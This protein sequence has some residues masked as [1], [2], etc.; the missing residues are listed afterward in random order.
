[1]NF[2][3]R[4]RSSCSLLA[5][6]G[7]LTVACSQPPPLVP[8]RSG[9]ATSD[10]GVPSDS[11]VPDGGVGDT[12]VATDGGVDT[13]VPP[14][15]GGGPIF[16]PPRI[17]TC[18]G[19]MIPS[20]PT[21]TCRV[22]AGGTGLLITGDILT[23]GEVFRGGQ[24][25]VN[26]MGQITCAACDCSAMAAGATQI[27]CPDGVVSPGLVNAHDHITF[28]N[29]L[30]YTRTDE[31]YEHR[32]DWRAANDGHTRIRNAGGMAS[33]AQ[34]AWIEL[35]HIVAGATSVHGSGGTSGYL[36][37]LD[38]NSPTTTTQLEG[39][40]G[41]TADYDTFP[42][43]DTSGTEL[44]GM[45]C[46][47]PPLATALTRGFSAYVPHIAE[48]IEQSA[49][50]EFLCARM[51]MNDIVGP[52]AAFI[53]GVG[54][55]ATDISEMARDGVDLIWSPRTNITLYGDTARVTE[56]AR[57]G[58]NIALG[59]DWLSTGSMNMLRELRCADTFNR[60]FLNRFFNDEQLWLMAT[61]NAAAALGWENRLGVLAPGRLADIA[62]YDARMQ[63]DHRAVLDGSP[64]SVALVLRGGAALYG[65]DAVVSALPNGMMCEALDVCTSMKRVCVSSQ[66]GGQTLAALR[67]ANMAQYPLFACGE[68]MNEPS[69][70]PARTRTMAPAASVNGST[71]Y[72]GMSSMDDRDGDGINNGMDNCP[73]VFNPIRPIDNMRQADSD[74][75]MVGDACDV[76]PLN[77][78]TMV[79]TRPD[80][81]DR[82]GDGVANATD[83]CP[84]N[85]NRDQ[86]DRDMDGKGDV[87]DPCPMAPNPGTQMCPG[88]MLTIPQ[89]RNPMSPMRPMTNGAVS[90]TGAVVTGVKTTGTN[91]GYFVQDR[92]ATEWGGIYVFTGTTRPTVNE[93]DLV[94]VSGTFTVFQGLEQIDV[95]MG[96]SMA[97]GTAAVPAPV[98]VTP[99]EVRT[100]GARAMALQSMLLRVNMVTCS[101]STPAMVGMTP[102]ATDFLVGTSAMDANSLLV[103]SFVVS[104]TTTPPTIRAMMGDTFVSITGNGYAFGMQ[105]KI[106]PRSMADVVRM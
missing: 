80:P 56:Y 25:A 61:R 29:Q 75:D 84:D 83:N 100:G 97:M 60:S 43:N 62:I 106:A 64:Q 69:C 95:R 99:A 32:H 74:M 18:A 26:A 105:N 28:N 54:L 6:A 31:R 49:R 3:L 23:P 103:T 30:P 20:L 87:C 11:P 40:P 86:A 47:M 33:A 19:D 13:G 85:A 67:T 9:D 52:Q 38:A 51:G 45:N 70:L 37:N 98:V 42:Y 104:D 12:G 53:H 58:V 46:G 16:M 44:R 27:V 89:I 14:G 101:G 41:P 36:R 2:T 34:L 76:C 66:P 82:D 88:A 81:N 8:D 57:L 77:A 22:M 5:A 35:R 72:T 94:N 39:A 78:G 92:M 15:D 79:C 24:V 59:T 93:G 63:R 91:F 4:F 65:D 96:A 50:N 48:G 68:P 90:I 21:G 102:I 55:L 1:M 17:T 71:V 7:A 73:D 10:L